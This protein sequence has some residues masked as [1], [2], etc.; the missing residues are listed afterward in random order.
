MVEEN[1]LKV[2]II[3]TFNKCT[4][5]YIFD[6]LNFCMNN[7]EPI[8]F[9]DIAIPS[10]TKT[11]TSS[12]ISTGLLFL[13]Q[14]LILLY[15]PDEWERFIQ[16]W[17]T[18]QRSQYKSVVRF[19]GANDLGIDIAGFVDDKNLEGVW[20][21]FQCKNYDDPITPSTA[22]L[23]VGKILW[24]SFNKLYAA[25]RKYFFIAPKDCG[26]KL[27][28]QLLNKT[29]LKD[30]L[31]EN[32]DNYCKTGITASQEIDMSGEFKTYCENFDYS[33]FTMRPCIEIINEHRKT[34]W[35]AIRFGGG[36][37]DRPNSA[38]PPLE[39]AENES[40]YITQLFEAYSDD[41]K[42][43]I[44]KFEDLA[45]LANL[46]DHYKRQ[47]EMFY[48]A[49]SLRNFA[50]DTVPPGTFED[51]QN[52]LYEGVIDIAA[53]NHN[54]A[55]DRLNSV[56]QGASMLQLTSNPLIT[57]TKI[58]DRKGICHQL[59]NEDKLVWKKP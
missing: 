39:I 5:I 55:L 28:K 4:N 59:A 54:S 9:V 35:H 12:R 17:V 41:K 20:D 57:V 10:D 15:P 42:I 47:R 52:E 45:P 48:H 43:E 58:Q 36:L 37:P 21:N 31:F 7:S 33:I 23:E 16:E 30:Y 2:Y 51:L 6:Y 32:W 25:P 56:T 22:V 26:M 8:K 53:A 19:S 50:R 46:E 11:Y 49:E 18:E 44:Q 3:V 27:K 40:R 29:L 24:Y 1:N 13:P 14:Q 34:P 38:S